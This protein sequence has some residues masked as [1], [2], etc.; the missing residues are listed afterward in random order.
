MPVKDKVN[1]TWRKTKH[2]CDNVNGTWRTAVAEWVKVGGLWRK[3]YDGRRYS[4]VFPYTYQM[5][6]FVGNYVVEEREDCLCAEISGHVVAFERFCQVGWRI[7]NVAG[8]KLTV[9]FEVTK[10]SGSLDSH[11]GIVYDEVAGTLASYGS[12]TGVI[13]KEYTNHSGNMLFFINFFPTR[14]MTSW[15][16]IYKILLDDEQI[17]PVL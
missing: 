14:D 9:T 8:K 16:K 1:G 6:N 11:D 3:T 12:D 10:D 15:I 4:C 7:K 2:I 13:T 5:E 17:Y